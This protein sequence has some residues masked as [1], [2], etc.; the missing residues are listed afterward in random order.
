MAILHTDADKVIAASV[1]C[2][3]NAI[4][5]GNI[6]CTSAT[7]VATNLNSVIR[8]HPA[9]RNR[10]RAIGTTIADIQRSGSDAIRRVYKVDV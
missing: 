7:A 1:V 6:K 3:D 4:R 8:I 9:I 5:T 10:H 2:T